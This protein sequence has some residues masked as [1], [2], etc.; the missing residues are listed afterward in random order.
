M[1][2]ICPHCGY[3]GAA[4]RCPN[5]DFPTVDPTHFALKEGVPELKGKVLVDRY[6][7]EELVGEGATG[8]V[9]KATH[10][11]THQDIA[12]K[13]LRRDLTRKMVAIRRFYAEARACANLAHPNIIRVFDFGASEDGFLYMAMEYL[14]GESLQERVKRLGPC[15]PSTAIDIG[16]QILAGLEFAHDAGIVHRDLKPANI[17]LCS[18]GKNDN[19]VK[20]LDF[21]LAK[22]VDGEELEVGITAAGFLVGSPGYISPEQVLGH[23]ADPRSDLYA[24]GVTLYRILT[25]RL[26]FSATKVEDLIRKQMST[27]PK[28]L[29]EMVEDREIPA[30]LRALVMRLLALKPENRFQ[31]AGEVAEALR[32][33]QAGRT[34]KF[35]AHQALTDLETQDGFPPP[36][37]G[38]SRRWQLAALAAALLAVVGLGIWGMSSGSDASIPVGSAQPEVV[39]NAK[40]PVET[41]PE[42]T[43]EA[44][45]ATHEARPVLQEPEPEERLVLVN[46]TPQGAEIRDG[47]MIVGVTPMNV[48]LMEGKK[49]SL[50]LISKRGDVEKLLLDGDSPETVS[51]EFPKPRVVRASLPA[52][53]KKPV[54]KPKKK[55]K[56]NGLKI[57]VL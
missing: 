2:R 10:L 3:E 53:R 46:S 35:L 11:S 49:R 22:A 28:P 45:P 24:L 25:G 7:F 12:I 42:K 36:L 18:V 30:P 38:S 37:G 57:K 29:P 48:P 34:P 27:P 43:S 16:L 41:T 13:M 31:S 56:K 1:E 32:D 6:Q 15:L 20:L 17:H 55:P 14:E 8:W 9:F 51:V 5:D 52:K 50:T 26:P 19:V 44:K 21:G 33:I 40:T 23:P 39:S 47:G 54:K 4:V